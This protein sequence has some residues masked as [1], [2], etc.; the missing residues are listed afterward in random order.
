MLLA[1]YLIAGMLL[2]DFGWQTNSAGEVEYIVQIE[3]DLLD[4]LRQGEEI[5]SEIPPELH[6]VRRVRIRVGDGPLPRGAQSAAPA[7]PI[8]RMADAPLEGLPAPPPFQPF[9]DRPA[10]DP[11]AEQPKSDEAP[12]LLQ[13]DGAF[14][15]PAS[16]DPPA[17]DSLFPIERNHDENELQPIPRNAGASESLTDRLSKKLEQDS[18]PALE[19]RPAVH[20]E[21]KPSLPE[22][23]TEPRPRSKSKRKKSKATSAAS[24]SKKRATTAPRQTSQQESRPWGPLLVTSLLLF[25][26]IGL[27]IYLGWITVGAIQRYRELAQQSVPA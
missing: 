24:G 21:S 9:P 5:V 23:E 15:P 13:R 3:P 20:L 19:A 25:A 12:P 1:A 18:Q 22:M 17:R 7:E 26:S 27:N 6:G 4:S 11:P 8:R 16:Q 10:I 2:T 14:Q